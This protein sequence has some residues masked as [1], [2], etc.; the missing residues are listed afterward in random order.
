MTRGYPRGTAY[1]PHEK[2]LAPATAA[3][4]QVLWEA[5]SDAKGVIQHGDRVFGSN[6]AAYDFNSGE[7]LWQEPADESSVVCKGLIFSTG[8]SIDGRLP[9]SGEV[10]QQTSVDESVVSFGLPTAKDGHVLFPGVTKLWEQENEPTPGRYFTYDVA[11]E[12]VAG[13]ELPYRTLAPAAVSSGQLYSAALQPAD[14]GFEYVVFAVTIDEGTA[15][16]RKEWATVLDSE[17]AASLPSR[18]VAVLNSHVFATS[19]DGSEMV[20]LDQ[21]SGAVSWR[22]RSVARID[23]FAVDFDHVY[24]AGTDENGELLVQAFAT[25]SGSLRFS[26]SLG[27]AKATGQLAVG[28]TLIYVGTSEGELVALEANGGRIVERA[29]LGGAVGAPVVSRGQVF[30]TT[31]SRIVA[32]G[33]PEQP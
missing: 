29:G 2:E 30:V 16:K 24:T 8:S 9:S 7:L 26:Q 12:T 17:A 14:G 6:G 3:S 22:S 33:L 32:L 1:N 19:A 11:S 5:E 15:G 27:R 28:G 25:G 10:A 21:R 23:Y 18:G 4:L 20:S 13:L 31:G